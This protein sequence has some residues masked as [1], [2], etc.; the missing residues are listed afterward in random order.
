MPSTGDPEGNL[1]LVR[2]ELRK[3]KCPVDVSEDRCVAGSTKRERKLGVVRQ[4]GKG[5]VTGA[6]H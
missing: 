1:A 4:A 3:I 2:R 6:D 5:T